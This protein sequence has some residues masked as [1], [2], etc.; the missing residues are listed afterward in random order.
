[1][2]ENCELWVLT[3]TGYVLLLFDSYADALFVQRHIK[4]NKVWKTLK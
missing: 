4:E 3:P 2:M 1:M